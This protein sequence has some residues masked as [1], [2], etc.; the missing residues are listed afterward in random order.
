MNNSPQ[1][2]EEMVRAAGDFVEVDR[3]L[4]PAVMEQTRAAQKCRTAWRRGGIA[5]T[6]ILFLAIP[7]GIMAT[8]FSEQ[9]TEQDLSRI[10][11]LDTNLNQSNWSWGMVHFQK[12]KT[13]R[14]RE[15]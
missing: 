2:I 7:L 11:S 1:S 5:A 15:K 14:A 9:V 10:E 4:R 3:Y 6:V 12:K 8:N 13:E